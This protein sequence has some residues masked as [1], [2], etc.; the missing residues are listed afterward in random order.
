MTNCS[1]PPLWEEKDAVFLVTG[2]TENERFVRDLAGT[3]AIRRYTVSEDMDNLVYYK[4]AYTPPYE[5]FE[6]LRRLYLLLMDAAGLQAQY[7]GVLA[8]DLSEWLDHP[9]EDYLHIAFKYLHDHRRDWKLLFVAGAADTG[10]LQPLVQTAALYLRPQLWQLCLFRDLPVLE[11]Y[12]AARLSIT[13]EACT[14]LAGLCSRLTPLHSCAV[15]E[16]VLQELQDLAGE[17]VTR[18]ILQRYLKEETSLVAILNG[19]PIE[20]AVPGSKEEESHAP[21]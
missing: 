11:H 20:A 7:R 19:G 21:I 16:Q 4:L 1:M 6:G 14:A 18:R 13:P 17:R 8:L 5:S 9:R 12:I 2:M 15:L 3:P 10:Q